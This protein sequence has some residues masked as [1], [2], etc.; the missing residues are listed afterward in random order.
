MAAMDLPGYQIAAIGGSHGYG[1]VCEAGC[2]CQGGRPVY[3]SL[4][5]RAAA[6]RRSS[7]GNS[8]LSPCLSISR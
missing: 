4:G 5:S 3:R 8:Q 2:G 1:M 7:A 6:A